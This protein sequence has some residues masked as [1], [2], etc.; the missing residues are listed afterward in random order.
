MQS[1][2]FGRLYEGKISGF[3]KGF[4][5]IIVQLQNGN[6]EAYIP[7]YQIDRKFKIKQEAEDSFPPIGSMVTVKY[8]GTFTKKNGTVGNRWSIN[9]IRK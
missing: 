2:K 3:S 1:Y 5:G 4:C 6:G 9:D 8:E 7:T